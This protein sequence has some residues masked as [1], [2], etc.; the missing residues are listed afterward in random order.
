MHANGVMYIQL[1]KMCFLFFQK[2]VRR[3]YK[4]LLEDDEN[5]DGWNLG[6]GL[7]LPIIMK[8]H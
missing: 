1:S 5:F 6:Y 7:V 3:V 4:V 8:K 2:E